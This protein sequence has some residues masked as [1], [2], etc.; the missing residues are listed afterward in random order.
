VR[1]R[2]PKRSTNARGYGVVHQTTRRRVAEFV[3]AGLAVCARCGLP[4]D[5]ARHEWDLDHRDDRR[6]Y[7]GPSH[8]FKRDCPA[9]GNRATSKPRPVSRKW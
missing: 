8:R 3:A 1:R 4:I 6:G 5:P 7:L 9:G 2:R